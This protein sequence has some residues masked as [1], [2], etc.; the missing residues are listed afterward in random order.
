MFHTAPEIH[1]AVNLTLKDIGHHEL[2]YDEVTHCIGQGLM[3]LLEHL[4]LDIDMSAE[5][6]KK[7][8][9]LFRQHYNKIFHESKPFPGLLEFL[10]NTPQK[11]AVGSNKDEK[12]VKAV[13]EQSPWNN[14]NWVSLNGG[15]TFSTK[16]PEPEMIEDIIIKSQ[17][18]PHEV[19]IVG[20]GSPDI[21][22]AKNTG[23][24]SVAV[25]YGYSPLQEL[26]DLGAD[27]SI[28]NLIE[29]QE[30]LNRLNT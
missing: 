22:V 25:S 10:S 28:D 1:R 24:Y 6:L 30:T 7:I 27:V 11:V 2:S 21:E 3:Y 12:Y 23:I 18:E 8:A 4:K 19:A 14:F 20:D 15:N 5:G 13:L 29:L 16:K 17:C 26:M 9:T